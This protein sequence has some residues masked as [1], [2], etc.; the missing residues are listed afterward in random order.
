MYFGL[1]HVHVSSLTTGWLAEIRR[2][3]AEASVDCVMQD[4]S[5]K[6]SLPLRKSI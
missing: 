6:S 4:R 3:Y 1:V 2:D 5:E